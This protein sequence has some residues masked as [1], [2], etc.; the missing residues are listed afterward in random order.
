MKIKAAIFLLIIFLSFSLVSYCTDAEKLLIIGGEANYPPFEFVDDD[1]E[2]RGFNVD[3]MKALS[4]E[5]GVEIKLVPM[6]WVDAHISLQNGSIDAIQGMNY[7]EARRTLYDFSDEY[8]I[9]SLACFVREDES[10]IFGIDNL[11]GHRVAVQRSDFAAYALAD[12]G[13]IEVVFF[14]DLNE[15]FKTL[16]NREVDAVLGNKLTGQYI[17]RNNKDIKSIKIVGNEI[18]FTFYGMAF[19]KGNDELVGE[20][21]RALKSLKKQGTYNK[22][23]EKWFGEDLNPIWKYTRYIVGTISVIAFIVFL[24]VVLFIKINNALKKEVEQRTLELTVANSQLKRNQQI[25][26]ESNK[27]KEQILNGI[28]NGLITFDNRGVITTINKSCENLLN[29]EEKDFIGKH[30]DK[31][32]LN[33]YFDIDKIKDCLKSERHFNYQEKRLLLNNK[34]ITISYILRPLFNLNNEN[35]GAVMTFNDITELNVLRKR[36]AENDKMNSL[37][38]V[39]S[40]ISHEIRNPL[41]TIKTYIDLL[42]LKYDNREFREKI[43]TQVPI[44]ISRLNDLL[45][46]LINFSKPKKLKKE[47][48][49]LVQLVNHVIDIFAVEMRKKQISFNYLD[50]AEKFLYADKQQIMQIIINILLNSIDAIE[51]N[52]SISIGIDDSQG[53]IIVSILDDGPGIREEDLNNLFDPF[54]TTKHYGTGLGLAISYQ[55]AK[56]NNASISITSKHGEWTKVKLIFSLQD[57]I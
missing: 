52:G 38:I 37:G 26:K 25:I 42:P 20:F 9:N 14:S 31:T 8:L 53:D 43:T 34:E 48:F 13:E 3:L 55:Y 1:G 56:D 22:I 17:L 6:D 57:N 2:Y 32:D 33:K 24:I 23:Y 40:G 36:L 54:F 27:Y 28:G 5:M 46:D 51:E 11:K 4:L 35:I 41:T 44:E 49:D 7:N 18:N 45:S 29:I 19:K 12:I 50:E 10:Q 47:K 30:I 39:V 21:N 15:A 16:L